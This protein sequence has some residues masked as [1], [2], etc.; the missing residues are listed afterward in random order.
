MAEWGQL[1][2]NDAISS[3]M[4]KIMEYH[5]ITMGVAVAIMF[6]V[7]VFLLGVCKPSLFFKGNYYRYGSECSWLEISWTILPSFILLFLAYFSVWNLYISNSLKF[8]SYRAQVMGHQ[9][10]WEYSYFVSPSM[11][12]KFFLKVDSMLSILVGDIYL[13][14]SNSNGFVLNGMFNSIKSEVGDVFGSSISYESYLSSPAFNE[15][16]DNNEYYS[17]ENGFGRW[18]VPDK[19]LF[20]PLAEKTA[21]TINTSDVMHS[22]AI[23]SLGLKMDAVP[24]RSNTLAVVAN[25][26]GLYPGNC[27]ELCG[28]LH[29]SMPCSVLVLDLTAWEMIMVNMIKN[30]GEV[31]FSVKEILE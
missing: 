2:F 27:S 11:M 14:S 16:V 13:K 26:P 18:S 9:W 3:N 8:L 29:S 22:W 1:G 6:L 7:S 28:V 30:V 15:V 31:S 12:S 5:D 10:F 21:V 20:M 4:C 17:N 23:P 19:P 24:G 25:Y